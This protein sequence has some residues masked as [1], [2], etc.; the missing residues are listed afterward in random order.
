MTK[1]NRGIDS[2]STS[3]SDVVSQ[4]AAAFLHGAKRIDTLPKDDP[5]RVAGEEAGAWFT[6]GVALLKGFP[7]PAIRAL[8][9]MIWD[10]VGSKIV[11]TAMGPDVPTLSFVVLRNSDV[12]EAM[13][14][15]PHGWVAMVQKEPLYQLGA[16]VFVGSQTVDHY[17]GRVVFEPK[18]AEKRARAHEAEFLLTVKKLSPMTALNDW[19][20]GVLRDFPEGLATERVRPLL[21]TPKPVVAPS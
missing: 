3:K 13:I 6:D 2:K 8:A 7:N 19:Q 16:L 17:N 12:H 10:I 4:I 21:Y 9:A 14:L 18:A 1:K 15:V 5:V 11:P 20:H